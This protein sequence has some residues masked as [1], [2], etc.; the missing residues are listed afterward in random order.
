MIFLFLDAWRVV[1]H[2]SPVLDTP[3]SRGGILQAI[4][5]M[6]IIL[7]CHDTFRPSRHLAGSLERVLF[8]LGSKAD[9][10]EAPPDWDKD[11]AYAV[12]DTRRS[13]NHKP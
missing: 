10:N 9:F 12:V 8:A 6:I 3:N 2:N 4:K 7:A 5:K 11:V 13:R 1:E